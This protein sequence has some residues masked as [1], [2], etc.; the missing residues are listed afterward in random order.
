MTKTTS[1]LAIAVIAGT[2]AVTYASAAVAEDA[3]QKN[4]YPYHIGEFVDNYGYAYDTCAF[5]YKPGKPG[6]P[7]TFEKKQVVEYEYGYPVYYTINYAKCFIPLHYSSK[8]KITFSNFKCIYTDN[9]YPDAQAVIETYDSKFLIRKG[10]THGTLT[11][12]FKTENE[13]VT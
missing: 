1:I 6:I 8:K 3:T 11:C 2:A 4:S 10:K 7:P 13:P 12:T 9:N 5:D